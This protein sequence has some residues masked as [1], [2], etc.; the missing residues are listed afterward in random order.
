MSYT[1]THERKHE[2]KHKH[3]HKYTLVDSVTCASLRHI[4]IYI[5]IYI[6]LYTYIPIYM[7]TYIYMHIHAHIRKYGSTCMSRLYAIACAC[8]PLA[9][10]SRKARASKSPPRRARFHMI[11]WRPKSKSH[12]EPRAGAIENQEQEP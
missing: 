3:K 4:Y 1:H 10:G 9:Q 8:K 7:Y 12:R 5:Y 6:Y 2:H 11:P